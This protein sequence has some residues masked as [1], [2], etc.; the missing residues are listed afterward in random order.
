MKKLLIALLFT[1]NASAM[2]MASYQMGLRKDEYLQSR[3]RNKLR[4]LRSGL[5]H[6]MIVLLL[7]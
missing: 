6:P 4:K 3:S 1:F 2:D 7:F 5:Q